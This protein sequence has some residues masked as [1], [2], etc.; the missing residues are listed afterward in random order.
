[1]EC[2]FLPL[3]KMAIYFT[4]GALAALVLGSSFLPINLV[5]PYSGRVPV[6]LLFTPVIVRLLQKMALFMARIAIKVGLVL[7][8]CYQAKGFGLISSLPPASE[9]LMAQLFWL[10][11]T[12]IFISLPRLGI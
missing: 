12:I 9:L 11:I 10:K 3:S 5:P 2:Q 6:N 8:R 1:M 7:S 4:Q